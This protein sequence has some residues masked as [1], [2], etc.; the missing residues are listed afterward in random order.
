MSDMPAGAGSGRS[1]GRAEPGLIHRQDLMAALR[2]ATGAG[3][4]RRGAATR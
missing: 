4:G 1:P 2:D 3:S